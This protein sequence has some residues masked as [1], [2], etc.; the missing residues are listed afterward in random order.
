VGNAFDSTNYPT[1]E[2]AELIAGDRWAWKREDIGSDYPPASYALSYSA[3]LETTG[4]EIS[5][6]ASESGSDYIVEVAAATTAPYTAGVYHWQAYVT[7]SSDSERVTVDD[8]KFEVI[9]NRDESTADPR[10]HVKITLDAI[11]AV[12][13]GRASQAEESYTI[14]GRALSRTPLKDL[15][16]MRNAYKAEYGKEQGHSSRVLVRF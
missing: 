12:I 13:Q 5:I 10:S 3:R 8:G 1:S 16:E 11:E 4:V 9:A 7:R 2:P 14:N 6:T 15:R